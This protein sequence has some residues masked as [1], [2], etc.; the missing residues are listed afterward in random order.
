[1]R[2]AVGKPEEEERKVDDDADKRVPPVGDTE[3]R[4]RPRARRAGLLGPARPKRRRR[5]ARC[6]CERAAAAG[7]E[8][9]LRGRMRPGKKVKI[10][11]FS[12][13]NFSNPFFKRF[14]NQI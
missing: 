1:V 5:R 12:F 10:L 14:S 9:G 13:S 3:R 4:K 11:F 6:G 2:L 8:A 7:R